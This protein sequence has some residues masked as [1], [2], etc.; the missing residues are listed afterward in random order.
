M[1]FEGST[2]C[3][4]S[5]YIPA[6]MEV[7]NTRSHEYNDDNL[8]KIFS[9]LTSAMQNTPGSKM[10]INEVLNSPPIIVP[11]NARGPP[12][13]YV[14]QQRSALADLANTVTWGTFALFGGKERSMEEYEKLLHNAGLKVTRFFRFRTF[15]VMIECELA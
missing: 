1:V 14:P 8:L 15:T 5:E 10:L 13:T 4:Y 6:I 11:A 12:S 7:A 2:V 9:H 3:E